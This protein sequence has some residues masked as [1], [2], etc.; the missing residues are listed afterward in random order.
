[1][2]IA[3]SVAAQIAQARSEFSLG[4]IKQNADAEKQVA[5]LLQSAASSVPGSPV[6]GTNV[7]IKA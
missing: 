6:R 7:N 1:M 5:D 3:A 2:E 4:A